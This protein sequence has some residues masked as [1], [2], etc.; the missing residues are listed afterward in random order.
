L[1]YCHG[2]WVESKLFF[3]LQ[4]MHLSSM[5]NNELSAASQVSETPLAPV[6]D[7]SDANIDAEPCEVIDISELEAVPVDVDSGILVTD[8]VEQDEHTTLDPEEQTSNENSQLGHP[9]SGTPFA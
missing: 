5:N 2:N 9:S 1:D 6:N 8:A 4:P 3:S 7:S